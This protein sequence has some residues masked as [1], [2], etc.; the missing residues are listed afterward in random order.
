MKK[1]IWWSL[2]RAALNE[3][4]NNVCTIWMCICTRD[5]ERDLHIKRAR[6]LD[7]LKR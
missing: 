4:L 3:Y 2:G 5:T 1:E 7:M 6:R